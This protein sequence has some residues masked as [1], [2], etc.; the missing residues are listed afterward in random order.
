MCFT[1]V[2]CLTLCSMDWGQREITEHRHFSPPCQDGSLCRM[3]LKV[4][5]APLKVEVRE[6]ESEW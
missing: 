1:E 4:T 2:S 6:R 3:Y 5:T